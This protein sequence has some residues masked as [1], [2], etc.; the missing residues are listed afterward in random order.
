MISFRIDPVLADRVRTAARTRGMT[1]SDWLRLAV[2][3][4]LS[5]DERLQVRRA[6]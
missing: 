1:L 6:A 4:Q 5:R 3:A 2:T